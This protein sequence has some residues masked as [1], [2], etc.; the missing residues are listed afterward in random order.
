M[1]I[2]QLF[3]CPNRAVEDAACSQQLLDLDYSAALL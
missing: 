3:F 1:Y 2:D